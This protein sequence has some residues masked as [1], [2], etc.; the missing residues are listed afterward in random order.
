MNCL[1][2]PGVHPGSPGRPR[3]QIQVPAGAGPPGAGGAGIGGTGPAGRGCWVG[4]LGP[5][6][7]SALWPCGVTG[8]PCWG[9]VGAEGPQRGDG[10]PAPSPLTVW[11]CLQVIFG[12][13]FSGKR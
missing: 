6:A 9:R 5:G 7:A 13:M 1:T 12:P 4:M 3:G 11:L 8:R 2:V 10:G